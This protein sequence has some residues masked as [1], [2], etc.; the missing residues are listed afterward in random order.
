MAQLADSSIN[1][2]ENFVEMYGLP[3]DGAEALVCLEKMWEEDDASIDES[4]LKPVEKGYLK[5]SGLPGD[6]SYEWVA[7]EAP[8]TSPLIAPLTPINVEC[9]PSL[10]APSPLALQALPLEEFSVEEVDAI[11]SNSELF[12]FKTAYGVMGLLGVKVNRAGHFVFMPATEKAQQLTCLKTTHSKRYPNY[13]CVSSSVQRKD[14]VFT[15]SLSKLIAKTFEP[16][17]AMVD[18]LVAHAD[19]NYLN[20]SYDNLLVKMNG[21]VSSHTSDMKRMKHLEIVDGE[22]WVPVITWDGCVIY[23]YYVSDKGRFYFEFA[24][25]RKHLLNVVG[26][27][28]VRIRNK[29][30]SAV[31]LVVR[32]FLITSP[33]YGYDQYHVC[34]EDDGLAVTNLSVFLGSEKLHKYLIA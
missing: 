1:T 34:R 31:Q 7:G 29:L 33:M 23:N 12:E 3:T 21:L 18:I 4:V 8:P 9:P 10:L 19:N 17:L 2:W 20:C 24:D 16:D 6:M 5:V 32:A 22:N 15:Q 30:M 28:R 13:I 27:Q 14:A 25:G 26:K 11:V